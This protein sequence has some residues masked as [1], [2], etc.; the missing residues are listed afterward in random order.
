MKFPFDEKA[1]T[2]CVAELSEE[3]KHLKA[4]VENVKPM[5]ESFS[6][7]KIAHCAVS[8]RCQISLL[9]VCFA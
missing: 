6:P 9:V 8:I 5:A 7:E 1:F 3:L 2:D 4:E